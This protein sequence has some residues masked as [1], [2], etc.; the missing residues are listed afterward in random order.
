MKE[1]PNHG[2]LH[3]LNEYFSEVKIKK[4]ENVGLPTHSQWYEIC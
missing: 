2:M 3:W 1:R 4:V